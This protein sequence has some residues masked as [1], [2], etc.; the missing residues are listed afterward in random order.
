MFMGKVIILVLASNAV[1]LTLEEKAFKNFAAGE[2]TAK[3]A[4]DLQLLAVPATKLRSSI[5]EQQKLGRKVIFASFPNETL[6][7]ARNL[8]QILKGTNTPFYLL[9]VY[10]SETVKDFEK[11]GVQV[12]RI[13]SDKKEILKRLFLECSEL[14]LSLKVLEEA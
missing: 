11:Q 1:Q 10:D 9:E 13:T 5:E 3:K 2:Q 4:E 6:R 12:K 8:A 14:A 7:N